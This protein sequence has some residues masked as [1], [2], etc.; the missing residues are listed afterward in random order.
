M[1]KSKKE[2][3]EST[4]SF[5][6]V[7]LVRGLADVTKKIKDTLIMLRLTKRNR[8]VV[9]QN[10]PMMLGM[11]IKAKDYVTWGEI[12]M[13]ALKDL[14]DKK[15]ME[16]EGRLQD[17]K[18]KYSYKCF[19]FAGKMYKPYFNL[20]SPKKGFGRKGIKVPFSVGGGLGDRKDKI[21]DL[22]K[23]MV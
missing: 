6:A 2:A 10:N 9:V 17:T 22:I 5:L 7:V 1:S 18:G 21:V 13:E 15:G 3:V 20:N 12:D 19:E 23:R 16:Y 8:C 4:K 14:V 11:I